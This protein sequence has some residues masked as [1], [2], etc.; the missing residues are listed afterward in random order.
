MVLVFL[1]ICIYLDMKN[2]KNVVSWNSRYA[3]HLFNGLKCRIMWHLHLPL[4]LNSY[5]KIYNLP[6]NFFRLKLL[7]LYH[8]NFP[9][10]CN[11]AL[12]LLSGRGC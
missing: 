10:T 12:T 1:Y 2:I 3:I 7:P 4:F 8:L 11:Y 9:H 6:I 5:T